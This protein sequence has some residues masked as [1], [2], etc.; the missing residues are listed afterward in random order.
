L[1]NMAMIVG[2]LKSYCYRAGREHCYYG[3]D[4]RSGDLFWQQEDQR[5]LGAPIVLLRP[6]KNFMVAN[7]IVYAIFIC[8]IFSLV[9]EV[10]KD[11]KNLE[12]AHKYKTCAINSWLASAKCKKV[13]H[14]LNHLEQS[15]VSKHNNTCTK[16][17]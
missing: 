11:C 1:F 17:Y 12:S 6:H 5:V 7:F 15:Y 14:C 9:S 8:S 16:K 4:E 10:M 2:C 3:G 13:F